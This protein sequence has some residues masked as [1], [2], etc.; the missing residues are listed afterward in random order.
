VP[1]LQLFDAGQESTIPRHL[2]NTRT[3][4]GD[5]RVVLVGDL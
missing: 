4:V 3:R 5:Q 1:A 2:K